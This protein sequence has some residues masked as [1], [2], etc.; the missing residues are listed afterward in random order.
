MR[1]LSPGSLGC[2]LARASRAFH[3]RGFLQPQDC[4]TGNRTKPVK[5]LQAPQTRTGPGTSREG[6]QRQAWLGPPGR[7]QSPLLVGGRQPSWGS[8]P[9]KTSWQLVGLAPAVPRLG[10]ALAGLA[11]RHQAARR[12]DLRPRGRVIKTTPSVRTALST[13]RPLIRPT[14]LP[15][16]QDPAPWASSSSASPKLQPRRNNAKPTLTEQPPSSGDRAESPCR[17]FSG[18]TTASEQ[19]SF[20][21]V[22]EPGNRG[23]ESSPPEAWPAGGG[24]PT[25]TRPLLGSIYQ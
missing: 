8:L 12:P 6:G 5:S 9:T 21:P 3:D 20:S 25:S 22:N 4:K 14:W 18:L 17:I 19:R 10:R 15:T 24:P 13:S 7:V 11:S 23:S 1:S 2:S 16:S